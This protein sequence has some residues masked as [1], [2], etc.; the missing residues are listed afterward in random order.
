MEN[1]EQAGSGYELP[2]LSLPKGG[3]AMQGMGEAVK[4]DDWTGTFSISIPLP[5]T[6]CR[7][8]TPEL[9]LRY[10]SGGGGGPFAMGMQAGIPHIA[11]STALGVPRYDRRDTF[12]FSEEGALT[13]GPE[14]ER[15][16]LREGKW[17]TVIRYHPRKEGAFSCIEKWDSGEESFWQVVTGENRTC[18]YGRGRE[19]RTADPKEDSRIFAW[20]LER[21][22]DGKG[23]ETLY[24][25]SKDGARP[26]IS[27]IRYGR[28][29]D[30]F[31]RPFFAFSVVFDYGEYDFA[32][33]RLA[34]SGCKAHIPVRPCPD[35]EDR[36]LSFRSGFP[37]EENRLC[38][39][40]ALF[41]HFPELGSDPCLVKS[42][43]FSYAPGSG[44]P[45]GTQQMVSVVEKGYLRRA[46]GGYEIKSLPDLRLSYGKFLPGEG[47][48][49][50]LKIDGDSPEGAINLAGPAMA[51]LYGEGMPGLLYSGRGGTWYCRPL[52]QGAYGPPENPEAFPCE[53]DLQEGGR[54]AL[55]SLQGNGRLDLVVGTERR[56]GY[57]PGDGEGGFGRFSE[58]PSYAPEYGSG[59]RELLDLSGS[60]RADL[61]APYGQAARLYE[62]LGR[63]GFGQAVAAELPPDFPWQEGKDELV[64]FAPVFGD[65]L[66]HRLRIR[67]NTVEC[68]PNLGHGRFGEKLYLPGAPDFS[69]AFDGGRLHFADLN[70]N[71]T[72]D[73]VYMHVR[74]A[75]IY[76]NKG[77]GF[78]PPLAVELPEDYT[79]LDSASFGDVDGS[80]CASLVFSK[81][82]ETIRHYYYN[83]CRGKKPYLLEGIDN[84]L[85]GATRIL[86]KSSVQ[87]YMEDRLQGRRWEDP[88]PYAVHVVSAVE[89]EDGVTREQFA[90]GYAYHQG[91]YDFTEREFKGF[92][93]V[94][95]VEGQGRRAGEKGPETQPAP[96]PPV[97]TKRWY[98]TGREPALKEV[99]SGDER[100]AFLNRKE[101]LGQAGLWEEGLW[102]LSGSLLRE[103]V[104][105]LDAT[106]AQD[107]P[108][109][110]EENHWEA[111]TLQA[112][113][114]ERKGSFLPW[115]KESV[116]YSYE[117]NPRDPVIV[118]EFTLQKDLFGNITRSSQ[119]FYPRRLPTE[120]EEQKCL[121]VLLSC[122]EYAKPVRGEA[123]AHLPC[124]SRIYSLAGVTPGEDGYFTWEQMKDQAE[125]ALSHVL[126]YGQSPE[127]SHPQA[128]SL[129]WERIYYWDEARE[130]SLPLGETAGA[131]LVHHQAQAVFPQAWVRDIFGER[132]KE[133]ML[134]KD[135]GYALEA[136]HWWSRGMVRLYLPK[137]E[138]GYCLPRGEESA[139]AFQA[140]PCRRKAVLDYDPYFLAPVTAYRE[141]AG[142]LVKAGQIRLDYRNLMPYE[143]K[144]EN[145][146]VF[147][148]IYDPLSMV[149]AATSYG[150]LEGRLAGDGDRKDYAG[151]SPEE[152][153]FENV[154]ADGQRFL[155]Q[156]S[157]YYYYDFHA[158]RQ[159]RQPASSVELLRETAAREAAGADSRRQIKIT[160]WDG[161]GREAEKKIRAEE[162]WVVSGRTVYNNKGKP[163]MQYLPFF[164]DKAE[165]ESREEAEAKQPKP[166]ILHCDPLSRI[167]R[168]DKPAGFFT[169][170]QFS[171]WEKKDYDENDTIRDSSWEP[172]GDEDLRDAWEKAAATYNTPH[173][174]ILDN[175]GNVIAEGDQAEAGGAFFYTRHGY[176][177]Q[178]GRIWSAD[179]RQASAS[180]HS[181]KYLLDMT[182]EAVSVDSGDSGKA[183][184]LKNIYS[185]PVYAWDGQGVCERTAY[186][187]LGRPVLTEISQTG[188]A[189]RTARR[190]IYGEALGSRA[191]DRNLAGRI[192]LQ[193]DGSGKTEYRSYTKEGKPLRAE[194]TLLKG[195]AAPDYRPETALP[196]QGG[197]DA[198]LEEESWMLGWDYDNL[199]RAIGK[200]SPE[201]EWIRTAY[202]RGGEVLQVWV[203]RQ[204][205]SQYIIRKIEYN[206][207]S[208]RTRVAYGNGVE[209]IWTY[210]PLTLRL[211]ELEAKKSGTEACVLQK[212][213]YTTDPAGNV[214]RMR[215]L[216]QPVVFCG[217][218]I[219]RP[220]FDYTYDGLYRLI[221]ASGRE[222]PAAASP[223]S[224]FRFSKGKTPGVRE[225][226]Q[227]DMEKLVPYECSYGYDLSGNLVYARRTGD[228]GGFTASFAVEEGSNRLKAWDLGGEKTGLAVDGRG[229]FLNLESNVRLDWNDENFLAGAVIIQ[230]EGK[231]SDGEWYL[232]DGQGKRAAKRARRL[233]GDGLVEEEETIYLE[234]FQ[235]RR[236]FHI[237]EAGRT[238]ILD[239]RSAAVS[240]GGRCAARINKWLLDKNHRETEKEGQRDTRYQL[241][242][243][244]GSCCLEL[245]AAAALITYEEYY[246]Y[247]GTALIAGRSQREVSLK[248][249]RYCAKERDATGLYYYGA[250]YYPPW[251]LRFISPDPAGDQDGLNRYAFVGGNP[252][253]FVD[254]GGELR[255]GW[256]TFLAGAATL[257]VG[258]VLGF[259][260]FAGEFAGGLTAVAAVAAG[261]AVEILLGEDAGV[262]ERAGSAAAATG[263]ASLVGGAVGRMAMGASDAA[264]LSPAATTVIGT[265]ASVTAG[266]GTLA[267]ERMI[268]PEGSM[269][270][271]M[272][273]AVIGTIGGSLLSAC[274]H[275]G[276]VL[277]GGAH[278]PNAPLEGTAPR[279]LDTSVTNVATTSGAVRAYA[280]LNQSELI[281]F[282][283]TRMDRD[284]F[285]EVDNYGN[286]LCDIVVV[287]GF[288]QFSFPDRINP[289]GGVSDA[290]Y[291]LGK[292]EVARWLR[293]RGFPHTDPATGTHIPIKLISC[294]G[295]FGGTFFSTAKHIATELDT[296]V[297]G[298][299]WPVTV[300]STGVWHR[301]QK[302][303][304]K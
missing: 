70:G 150:T 166:A 132:L 268:M 219:A 186:D 302:G 279:R 17:W 7:D 53:R 97:K 80:G 175:R 103:E 91:R 71:G 265:A 27:Q 26:F 251:L 75:A 160:F 98:H 249:Y 30:R 133:T 257:G 47:S 288:P 105:G 113:G 189:S 108:Y 52:G 196:A 2:E 161:L 126:D 241:A 8:M 67:E 162:N 1:K 229:N 81:M 261:A 273:Y 158:W 173:K 278:Q 170:T 298:S 65:G 299:Y 263:A 226:H 224:A 117:R 293:A 221:R 199:G 218:Q 303:F 237:K 62:S 95:M 181:V 210:D 259:C 296:T 213:V 167:I 297:Y 48:F 264:H 272:T 127:A 135:C 283:H 154:I 118:H 23:N 276:W 119:A 46:D 73:L 192:H 6:P 88:V 231:Q 115:K 202:G 206:A 240:D 228:S 31:G 195:E 179:P 146:N 114:R 35:R 270:G 66:L 301:Y 190:Y 56:G 102:A 177:P 63:Q 289:A 178:G 140:D 151:V 225:P 157:A 174:Q 18:L 28:C 207:V 250:R 29:P 64:C 4:C 50:E 101:G 142:K 139:S 42:V 209:T 238:C 136:G 34:A 258:L 14:S 99:F 32:Q 36:S 295:A 216:A 25:Y 248:R 22:F 291:Y 5:L 233:L 87:Y 10:D 304:L 282:I 128:L 112:P 129:S 281:S 191:C 168:C 212:L 141:L 106:A 15:R 72:A 96:A 286:D 37:V 201:G 277:P 24:V 58:F 182:G 12:V 125:E 100:A 137:G 131:G 234:D 49:G 215:D 134:E 244:M 144:D 130:D 84:G 45:S 145:E 93:Q 271:M 246:P 156:M 300:D 269:E 232:Y 116:R 290:H 74:H 176:N 285:F 208:Q 60:G 55:F 39:T 287:H 262:G 13:R 89:I 235:I 266:L 82:G 138:L 147:Q 205:E 184:V 33:E 109:Y 284:H 59:W 187:S 200:G 148:V 223:S 21:A 124:E 294:Y 120:W 76:M 20:H 256:L 94:E 171:P 16:E 243:G 69:G 222:H 247:G 253:T 152:T 163:V 165:Y 230:R 57:Y 92:G 38:H 239:C 155:Q 275:F 77:F 90:T 188:G 194:K 110:V 220:L 227:N 211:K 143:R 40:V 44:D 3:G 245:D 68:W 111:D 159:K 183:D 203:E 51:D 197:W 149:I 267:L 122:R 78:A 19:A 169:K 292:E 254:G 43:G 255:G 85:G 280:E 79:P 172:K 260:G 164:S 9:S 86:Y 153:T 217:G 107:L 83:F 252:I 11:R 193:Y 54:Q 123:L 185:Q 180:R 198:A 121:Q 61:L 236:I 274:A 104:Y 41:H 242:N 204:K 214:T